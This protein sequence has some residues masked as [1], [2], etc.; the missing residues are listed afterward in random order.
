MLTPKYQTQVTATSR[1]LFVEKSLAVFVSQL[2]VKLKD[3]DPLYVAVDEKLRDDHGRSVVVK[4]GVLYWEQV[5]KLQILSDAQVLYLADRAGKPFVSA[6]GKRLVVSGKVLRVEGSDTNLLDAHGK[7]VELLAALGRNL[8]HHP[9]S[10]ET[11]LAPS[12]LPTWFPLLRFPL[13]MNEVQTDKVLKIPLPE[14]G[15]VA[16][17]LRKR[18][19][20]S[21]EETPAGDEAWMLHQA[22]FIRTAEQLQ[23]PLLDADE[24]VA[25]LVSVGRKVSPLL[26]VNKW[27]GDSRLGVNMDSTL[28]PDNNDTLDPDNND[29]LDP[30]N[31][32]TLDPD[33]NDTLDPDSNDT[34]GIAESGSSPKKA[35]RYGTS[36]TQYVAA[37]ERQGK[38]ANM[39]F[40]LV[41]LESC[42][43]QLSNDLL[44][45]LRTR[46]TTQIGQV[47]SSDARGLK[48]ST[49]DYGRAFAALNETASF[50]EALSRTL[51]NQ[52]TEEQRVRDEL[53]K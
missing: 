5:G 6:D 53:L 35:K 28:D 11:S 32:D 34:L 22:Q 37:L 12:Q 7:S 31:N 24:L 16:L 8:D 49:C 33:S 25:P 48:Y 39:Y 14:G 20:G 38:A 10:G 23:V 46:G 3:A 4:D 52:F 27:I 15:F 30:D 41:F 17:P 9:K 2:A 47:W 13:F 18:P 51:E 42:Q 43:S 50:S 21:K 40:R 26:A 1:E 29:T 45:R 44:K 19:T 36:K